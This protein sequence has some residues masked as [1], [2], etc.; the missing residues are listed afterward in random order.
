MNVMHRLQSQVRQRKLFSARQLREDLRV[1]VAG[2]IQQLPAWPDNMA[3]VQNSSWE[4][5]PPRLIQQV[6]LDRR[7][8]DAVLAERPARLLLGGGHLHA[9]AM[10]PDRATVQKVLDLAVQRRD[11]LAGAIKREADHVD[12]DIGPQV[13]HE[14]AKHPSG[15]L[16]RAIDREPLNRLP[17]RMRL[18][19]LA[20]AA[21]DRYHLVAALYQARHQVCP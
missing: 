19:W 21:A 7:L 3:G 15:L 14:R 11:Q 9:G 13:A 20:L 1:E 17:G 10:H 8:L 16:C 2:R 5:I 12:H 6:R 4:S 18:V